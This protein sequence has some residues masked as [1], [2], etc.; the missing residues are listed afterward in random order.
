[1]NAVNNVDADMSEMFGMCFSLF[2]Q[3]SLKYYKIR[4]LCRH[5]AVNDSHQLLSSKSAAYVQ[6]PR[7]QEMDNSLI[8]K[9][10]VFW[11]ESMDTYCGEQSTNPQGD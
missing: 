1:M 3:V 10:S 5:P 8:Y 11:A 2:K 9:M 7:S 6:Q 4:F